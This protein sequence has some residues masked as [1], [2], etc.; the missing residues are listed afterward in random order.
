[1]HHLFIR[2]IH[3]LIDWFCNKWNKYL[4]SLDSSWILTINNYSDYIEA[5]S[6]YNYFRNFV[7]CFFVEYWREIF[8]IKSNLMINSYLQNKAKLI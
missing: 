2:M 5:R 8:Q 6:F 4:F 1:M 3:L 7:F